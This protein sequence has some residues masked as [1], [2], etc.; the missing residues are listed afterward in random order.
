MRAAEV[1]FLYLFVPTVAILLHGICRLRHN[2]EVPRALIRGTPI[3]EY[4]P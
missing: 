2:A 3:Y 1:G 4:A